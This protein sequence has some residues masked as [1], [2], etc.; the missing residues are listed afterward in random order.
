MSQ[1]YKQL[2][3]GQLADFG[4]RRTQRIRCCDCGLVHIFRFQVSKAGRIQFRAWRDIRA[5]AR[6][7]K[8]KRIRLLVNA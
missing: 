4:H 7:R 6:A 1:R 8:R 5:T 3:D 2:A